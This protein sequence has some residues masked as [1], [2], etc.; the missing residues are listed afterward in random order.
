M[1]RSLHFEVSAERN[2]G[3]KTRVD[4]QC[5]FICTCDG[6]KGVPVSIGR[7]TAVKDEVISGPPE[8]TLPTT[9]A[10]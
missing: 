2:R 4:G 6:Q 5:S 7:L 9:S 8:G 10:E 1:N 3:S